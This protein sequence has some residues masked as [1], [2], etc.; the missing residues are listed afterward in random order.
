MEN[1]NIEIETVAVVGSTALAGRVSA[2]LAD[3][4][5]RVIA[6]ADER[7]PLDALAEAALV[8]EAVPDEHDAKR[9]AL[10]AVVA[11]VGPD[12][13]VATT[14]AVLS[15]TELAAY[16]P[17]AARVAGFHLVDLLA[18]SRTIEVVRALHTDDAVVER[19]TALVG[20]LPAMEAVVVRDRPGFLVDAL[21]LP[22]LNDVI[23]AYDE[24]LASAEDID[25]AIRLG[26]GYSTGPLE[27]L[28]AFGLDEHLRRTEAVYA[29]TR[30]ERYAAPPLLR[31]MVAAGFLGGN[32]GF[33]DRPT[34][35]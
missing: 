1:S 23:G 10:R 24:E 33:R 18:A 15:V 11:A 30:D 31:R 28:D 32:Q 19:L 16:V 29:A 27:L 21:Q 25:V 22:Y 6:L 34:S 17:G 3:A 26:L 12:I 14:T 35:S 7:G 8:I 2:L 4:G 13:P 9:A 5:H 20:T